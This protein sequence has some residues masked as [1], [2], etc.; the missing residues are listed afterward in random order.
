MIESEVRGV[1]VVTSSL[2]TEVAEEL[3]PAQV[4]VV[5]CNLGPPRRLVS[6][7]EIDHSRGISEALEH[8]IQLGHRHVAVVAGPE[9]NRT[10]V[11]IKKAILNGLRKAGLHPTAVLESD[12]KLD[13][14]ASAVSSLLKENPF[15]TALFC[16]NDLTA[17][18]AMSALEELGLRVPED[19]SVVGFDDIFFARLARPPLTTVHIP[20]ERL[21]RLV[22]ETLD[23]MTRSKR[24]SGIE[25]VLATS[26]VIRKSTAPPRR[27]M[28]LSARK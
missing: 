14:G 11:T 12:Y 5:Y 8:L 17:L 22:L 23:K 4:G 15:P 16:G 28:N 27:I 3:I 26:L 1:G 10:A 9:T 6:N 25:Q 19:V 24:H 7:I 2:D 21:G 18:G 20:R 13:G